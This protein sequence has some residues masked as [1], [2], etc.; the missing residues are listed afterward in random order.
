[1]GLDE[2]TNSVH[3]SAPVVVAAPRPTE[4]FTYV[5]RASVFGEC[6]ASCS[7]GMQHRSVE[8]VV[9]DSVNPHVVDETYCIAQRLQRP[10]SQQA[11]NMHPCTAEYSV[12]SFSGV[13][14]LQLKTIIF[15][16]S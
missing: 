15:E 6:S 11:C 12:S 4:T 16:L 10:P 13:C 9:E 7:G 14:L 2:D 5:Y 8:C 3:S 1:M